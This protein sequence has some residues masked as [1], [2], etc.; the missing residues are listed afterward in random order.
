MTGNRLGHGE[1][2]R[3]GGTMTGNRSID[4]ES[5][6]GDGESTTRDGEKV[7]RGKGNAGNRLEAALFIV[8]CAV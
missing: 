2:T 8:G 4:G 1:S 3:V 6:L 7:M 5:T